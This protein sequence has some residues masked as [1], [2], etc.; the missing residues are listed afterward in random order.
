MDNNII[1]NSKEIVFREN[2]VSTTDVKLK[3]ILCVTY[4]RGYKES[5]GAIYC[6]LCSGFFSGFVTLF[7]TLLTSSFNSIC[8][9]SAKTITAF[10]C[11]ICVVCF[12][13]GCVFLG[14]HISSKG[15]CPSDKRDAAVQEIFDKSLPKNIENSLS[16]SVENNLQVSLPSFKRNK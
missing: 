15:L 1:D 13:L 8:G 10:V 9:I 4:E 12:V 14:M 11:V 7:L 2:K 5:K 6:E 16:Q 3:S